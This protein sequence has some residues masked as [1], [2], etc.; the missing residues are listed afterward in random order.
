MKVVGAE[1]DEV[2]TSVLYV[3]KEYAFYRTLVSAEQLH[4]CGMIS[5]LNGLMIPGSHLL[6][7][8]ILEIAVT[9]LLS[10]TCWQKVRFARLYRVHDALLQAEATLLVKQGLLQGLNGELQ[11][12]SVRDGLTGLH[13]RRH[14][15]E[16]LAS[17]WQRLTRT[18]QSLAML[19]L[20]VDHF[21]LLND[22]YGHD[23]GDECLRRIANILNAQPRRKEDCVVR[24]G[25]EEF[26]I[27][28]PGADIK[29]ARCI[30]EAIRKEVVGL[31]IAHRGSPEGL[32]SVSIGVCSHTP[33]LAS[34]AET[35]VRRTDQAMYEAKQA[36]RNQ[37][38][39]KE[40][41]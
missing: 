3:P 30:A 11:E 36:G 7:K 26:A 16:R 12:L 9:G 37:V 13:N 19:F 23:Y 28:L 32:V 41:G 38:C 1:E 29:S 24:F 18:Q 6:P 4:T 8:T 2:I 27:L 35:L 14:F 40:V 10:L 21:K 15:D 17:E 25:G 33:S 39:F 5:S 20:D 22:A 34:H 31:A